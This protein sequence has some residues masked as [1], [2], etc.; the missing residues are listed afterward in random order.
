MGKWVQAVGKGNPVNGFITQ[1]NVCYMQQKGIG[2]WGWGR[3]VIAGNTANGS[4]PKVSLC[5]GIRESGTFWRNKTI[6]LT[7]MQYAGLAG[8]VKKGNV[9][10]VS[11]V[12]S[13][14]PG[15]VVAYA[16]RLQVAAA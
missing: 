10:A 1:F 2:C 11:S 8:L 14:Q 5:V 16:Q 13:S 4:L 12:W 15:I 3:G 9:K 6:G 7:Q